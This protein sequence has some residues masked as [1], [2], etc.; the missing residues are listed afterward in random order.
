MLSLNEGMVQT[1]KNF[2]DVLLRPVKAAISSFSRFPITTVYLF[3]LFSVFS[4]MVAYENLDE[5][6]TII[7]N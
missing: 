2:L 1:V 7:L 3:A 6:V 5:K 4:F